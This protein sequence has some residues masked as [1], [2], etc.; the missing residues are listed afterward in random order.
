MWFR[1]QPQGPAPLKGWLPRD[2]GADRVVS[3]KAMRLSITSLCNLSDHPITPACLEE[4][5]CSQHPI[6]HLPRWT[7]S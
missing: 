1:V 7:L 4:W 6:H 3:L 2:G 5:S